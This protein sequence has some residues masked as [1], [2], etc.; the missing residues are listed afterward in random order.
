MVDNSKRNYTSVALARQPIVDN[1]LSVMGYE[2]LYRKSE[3]ALSAEVVDDVGAT[4]QVIAASLFE[5]GMDALVGSNKA[6]INFPRSYLLNPSSVPIDKSNTVIEVLENSV[7]DAVLLAALRRWVKEG[8]SIALDDFVF[9]PKLTPFVELADYIKLDILALGQDE[10]HRQVEALRGFDVKI[11]AEKIETWD[12]YHFCRLLEVDYF[13][14]YFFERPET[15]SSKGS[16]VQSMTLLQLMAEM[17]K[18]DKLSMDELERIVSQDAGL[19]HK[20]LRYL[21]SPYTGLVASID[22]VRLAISLIGVN[23][24]KSLTNLLLM[25]EMT[26][27]RP[28]LLEQ[29]MVRAKHAELFAKRRGYDNQERYFLAGLMSMMDVCTGLS[30]SDALGELPLPSE[31]INA[32]VHRTGRVG[33]TLDLVEYYSN[34]HVIKSEKDLIDLEATYL[35]A[36]KWTDQFITS[37]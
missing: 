34:G 9:Q 37:F 4:A 10:F 22:S 5:I 28:V 32:I 6:F 13:Q 19:V 14:G 30:L 29:I 1:N 23:Q 24:L 7:F 17:L 27:D 21:N 2:L 35:D 26:G 20:M 18:S 36:I 11:I 25:S 15:I 3:H 8:Y 33:N 16:K 31:F 12:E